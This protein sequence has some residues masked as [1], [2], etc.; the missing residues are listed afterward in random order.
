MKHAVGRRERHQGV[1]RAPAQAGGIAL[2]DGEELGGIVR[3]AAPAGAADH[4]DGGTPPDQQGAA[5][6]TRLGLDTS[7]PS[8][9]PDVIVRHSD[10]PRD[11]RRIPPPSSDRNRRRR[12]SKRSRRP[13]PSML[14]PSTRRARWPGPARPR[15]RAPGRCRS[16]R[17]AA[18]GPQEGTGGWAPQAEVGEA[19]FGQDGD[20]E[21][22]GRLHDQD[23]GDIGQD[24]AQGDADRPL[25]HS[26]RC[27]D[28]IVTPH[29]ERGAAGDAREHR[30]VED[31]DGEDRVLRAG[32]Q[33]RGDAGWRSARAGKAKMRSE[34]R[35]NASSTQPPRAA[36]QAPSATP[37]VRPMA[38][39]IR[40]TVIEV[41][42][43]TMIRESTSR[44][45]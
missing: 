21:L 1:G 30:D 39:A 11:R 14:R 15:A 32:A 41:C 27:A 9:C 38:T 8:V 7:A 3:R 12:G 33:H 29:G 40:P 35:D 28:E 36:A 24:M 2:H 37:I 22:D 25:P 26:R 31:G 43:P 19:R 13:S 10:S 44:P 20:G 6:R 42:A 34:V 5:R 45:R 16:G 18:C 4:G 17:R 23:A